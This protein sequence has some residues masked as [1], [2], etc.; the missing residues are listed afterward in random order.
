MS[1]HL[2][3][4]GSAEDVGRAP[5]LL[6]AF[7][8]AQVPH[9]GYGYDAQDGEKEINLF[10]IFLY[11]LHYR[12]LLASMAAV[13]L[14]CA[15]AATMMMT[16]KYKASAQLE[17]MVPSAKVF[18]DIEVTSES[19]D[20]RAFQTASEK[21]RSRAIAERVA[22][23]LGLSERADF[24][25]PRPSFSPFNIIS[26]AFG[27]ASATGEL[28]DY[29]P[30]QRARMAVERL[31]KN[32]AV[33]LVPNTSLLSITYSDQNPQYA[34]EIANQV[35]Q[36]FI[37][38]RVDQASDTSAQARK[39]I[40]E[41]V[42][43]AKAR[44]Q[45]SEEALVAYAKQAGITI[46]GDD[47]SLITASLTEINKALSA[48]VQENLDYGRMV[49]QINNGQGSSLEPVLKSEGLEKLRGKLAELNADYQ[50][51]RGL[52]KPSFPEMQQLRSQINELE[53]QINL[54]VR[55]ITDSIKYKYQE[56]QA[57]VTDLQRKLSELE[58]EQ[59][60]YQ[61]KN[62]QYT[63]LKREVD[64]NRSQYDSLISKLN[65]VSVGSELKNQNAAVVDL[66]VLPEK[67]YSPW[68][69]LNLAIGLFL[70]MLAG[71]VTIYVLELLNNTFANPEQVERE[72]QLPLLGILPAIEESEFARAM[73]DPQS[74]LSEAYRSLRTS[75]QF[76][77]EQG[78]PHTLAVTSS[79]PSEG[80]S[81]TIYKLAED[82]AALG[83]KVLVIDADMRRP[84]LHRVFKMDN[85]VGLSNVLT[86]TIRRDDLPMLIK[87]VK[88]NLSLMTAGTI[89]PNPADL[90]SSS[91]MG[92][93]LQKLGRSYDV[94]LV[95]SPPV[96][97]LSDAL[98]LS[99]MT[100]AT[101]L[102]V[103][104]N[105]VTRKAASAALKRLRN[106][107]GNIVGAAFT[108]FSVRRLDYN[109]SYKYLNYN[110]Y[111][112]GEDTPKLEDKAGVREAAK[113][114][115]PEKNAEK[116]SFAS[117]GRNMR[118]YLSGLA[119]RIKSTS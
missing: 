78:A 14:V 38:Q 28:N 42:T 11:V 80:K 108:K 82:F 106:A 7:E 90:L 111:Q 3:K 59:T 89:P 61:D 34:Y 84:T 46:T 4:I 76:S 18:Q 91:K 12:W 101:L 70:S 67:P 116:W 2:R 98:I 52:F 57:K 104:S 87:Q 118:R 15:F 21:L 44:L 81:T 39:F 117:V 17:V 6:H 19:S 94:V 86:S 5:A 24:L 22:F 48:A 99:R 45:Q 64:S 66:A 85:A 33:T 74:G 114:A 109:Y 51:K 107:G 50:Q 83:A 60:N 63:I 35:A 103:S 54:G 112:Y 79:E 100:E 36:S 62:I 53:N 55:A 73:A 8:G 16:P 113:E 25:F 97:G 105:Q 110:Y 27:I 1:S 9:S 41:Q 23:N 68:L 31:Q 20:V 65:E 88:P 26:R 95:D 49:Q 13:G 32:L 58:T 43:Q 47:N 96:I 102:V 92:L 10:R 77:G 119:D 56:T 40:Q 71:A 37:D 69:A 72:L 75:L 115:S 30:E 93:L 29:P